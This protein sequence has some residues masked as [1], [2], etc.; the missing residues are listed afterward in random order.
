MCDKRYNP[1]AVSPKAMQKLSSAD[2]EE[3]IFRQQA[4]VPLDG[5]LVVAI[6]DTERSV[7]HDK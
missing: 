2:R 3:I 4:Y 6:K 7:V 1:Q 5:R